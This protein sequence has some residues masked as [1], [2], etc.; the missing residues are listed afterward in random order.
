MSV[1]KKTAAI[2]D[3][4]GTGRCSLTVALPVL[5]A[6]GINCS[7]LPTAVLSNHTGYPEYYFDDYTDKMECFMDNWKKIGIKFD[8]IYTG[9]L[10][11][12]KQIETVIKFMN[13][14]R[15]DDT[16]IVVDPVMGD[17]GH[18][19]ATYTEELCNEMK[20]LVSYAD[21]VTPNITEACILTSSEYHGEHMS[22]KE[23]IRIAEKICSLGAKSAVITGQKDGNIIKNFACSR[24]EI[25]TFEGELIPHYYSGTGDVFASVITGMVTLGYDVFSAVERATDFVYKTTKFSYDNKIDSNDGVCFEKFLDE[26][27]F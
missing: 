15:K 17:N 10:G 21:I 20:R 22:D 16:V 14:F 2:N 13:M 4:S 26:L 18:M 3:L 23:I 12:E 19:Y 5:C 7:V 24:G 8:S 25:K 11:S 1:I 9:F 27:M 6:M